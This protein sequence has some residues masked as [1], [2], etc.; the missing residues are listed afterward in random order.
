MFAEIRHVTRYEYTSAVF[1][2]EHRLMLRPKEGAALQLLSFELC[3]KPEGK[4]RWGMD[5]FGNWVAWV[6]FSDK[7]AELEIVSQ[8]RIKLDSQKVAYFML[9]S[10]AVM[11]PFAYDAEE[12]R[13]LQPYLEPAYGED[14][15]VIRQWLAALWRP[16]QRVGTLELLS[17]INQRVRAEFSYQ[18]R[19]EMGVQ[20]PRETLRRRMGSCRDFAVLF[21]EVCRVLGL[22]SRFASGYI[23]PENG[24]SMEHG[25][26]HAWAEVYLPGAGWRGVDPTLG[27]WSDHKH[28]PVA[29]TRHASQAAPVSGLFAGDAGAFK[30]LCVD[31]SAH[32]VIG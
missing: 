4:I 1:L 8:S 9:E 5:V 3:V 21:M 27:S 25:S 7:V 6:S 28:I 30:S 13:D 32:L 2:G 23:M 15:M 16:T 17:L 20:S 31:V 18:R 24:A 11:F 14:R 19:D 26:T 10:D 12:Q 22:A 29:M